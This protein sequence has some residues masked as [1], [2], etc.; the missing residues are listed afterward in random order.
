MYQIGRPLKR[1][2]DQSGG[3]APDMQAIAGLCKNN[4]L[5]HISGLR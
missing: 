4:H 3:I 1:Y 5:F 2:L